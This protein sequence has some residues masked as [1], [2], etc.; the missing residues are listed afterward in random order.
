MKK[1][2]RFNQTAILKHVGAKCARC[3]DSARIADLTI[4]HKNHKSHDADWTN[5]VIYCRKCHSIVE[6]TDK[7][8]RDMK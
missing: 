4:H 7:K 2:K 3:K 8:K 1:R 5:I 6:G